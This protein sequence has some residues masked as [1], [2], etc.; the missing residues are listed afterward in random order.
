MTALRL[1]YEVSMKGQVRKRS[2]QSPF[3]KDLNEASAAVVEKIE[4]LLAAGAVTRP[5]L[6]D[7]WRRIRC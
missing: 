5:R 3:D 6:A 4:E 2:L 7:T 1:E